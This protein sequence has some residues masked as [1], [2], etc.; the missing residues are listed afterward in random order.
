METRDF[1]AAVTVV[2]LRPPP[3]VRRAQPPASPGWRNDD[4]W[5]A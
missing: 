2:A 5:R 1:A 4:R 3:S